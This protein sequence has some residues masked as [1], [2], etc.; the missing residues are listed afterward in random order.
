MGHS[1]MRSPR[2]LGRTQSIGSDGALLYG[3]SD[4]RWPGGEAVAP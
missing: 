3:A 1:L 2:T 4:T